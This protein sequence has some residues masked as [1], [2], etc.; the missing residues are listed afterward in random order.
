MRAVA[1][2]E[3]ANG[4]RANAIAPTAIRTNQNLESMGDK[5]NYV[6]RETI[7]AW[8]LWLCSAE[9]GPVNGQVI[10]LG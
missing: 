6:E 10:R 1:S 7:A 5:Q 2:E 9:S 8:V 3:K 4:V